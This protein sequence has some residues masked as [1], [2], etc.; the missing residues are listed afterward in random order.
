MLNFVDENVDQIKVHL[1]DVENFLNEG[2]ATNNDLLK[3]KVQL[4]EVQLRQID[5]V[6]AV[7]LSMTNLNNI[8]EFPLTTEI[9]MKGPWVTKELESLGANRFLCTYSDPIYGVRVIPFVTDGNKVKSF[10]LSVHWFVE[11]TTYEFVKN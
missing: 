1:T 9:E 8:I 3:V 6:N 10:T 4:G 11:F 5:V 7:K 2:L